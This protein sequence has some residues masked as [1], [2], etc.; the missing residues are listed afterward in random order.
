MAGVNVVHVPYR[1]SAPAAVDL[2]AGQ[3][4]LAMNNIV[5]TLPH[6][7]SGRLRALAVS[8][9]LRSNVLS[10]VPTVAES[11]LPGYEAVQWYGVLLP[12]KV[13][14]SIAVYLHK[15]ITAVLQISIVR[16]R[17]TEEGGDVAGGSPEQFAAYIALETE[18]WAKVVKAAGVKAE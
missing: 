15:E 17:L 5:P 16:T 3:V 18:K 8:G 9:P 11:G 7:K 14:R 12:A 1:G 6:V 2:I 4:Q 10:E 13:P